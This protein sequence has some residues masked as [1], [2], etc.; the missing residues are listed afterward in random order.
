MERTHVSY[1]QGVLDYAL[2]TAVVGIGNDCDFGMYELGNTWC[3]GNNRTPLPRPLCIA[4]VCC[5]ISYI[6][7]HVV[8]FDF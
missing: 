7:F 5:R 1:F 3:C 2:L 4:A 8:P 6:S